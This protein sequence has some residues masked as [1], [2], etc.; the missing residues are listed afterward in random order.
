VADSEASLSEFSI[1]EDELG[2][3]ARVCVDSDLY[4]LNAIYKAA[5]W[6]TDYCYLFLS[7][8]STVVEVEFR[9]KDSG[10]NAQLKNICGEFLNGLLDQSVRQ[11]V[12]EETSEIRSTLLKKAF[13][14]AK[15]AVAV[16]MISDES[17]VP[18]ATSSFKNDLLN[19]SEH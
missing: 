8:R 3:Y 19:I 12:L 2:I 17:K 1:G 15:A 10:S 11:R 13:F 18:P 6:F 14:D 7:K 5:Y 16:N 4:T 9:L